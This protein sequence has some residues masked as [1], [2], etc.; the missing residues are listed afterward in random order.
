LKKSNSSNDLDQLPTIE[1]RVSKQSTKEIR[2]MVIG[3]LE[4][5]KIECLRELHHEESDCHMIPLGVKKSQASQK[6]RIPFKNLSLG[7]DADI[8]FTFVK[9]PN[10]DASEDD[11]N[12]MQCFEFYC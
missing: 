6:F 12:L 1:K 5:P 9:L 10:Q 11:V 2:V 4:N 7:Q 3:R 8:E